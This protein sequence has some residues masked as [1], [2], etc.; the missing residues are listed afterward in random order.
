MDFNSILSSSGLTLFGIFIAGFVSGIF[1]WSLT[2]GVIFKIMF[3][4]IILSV[5]GL[6]V[7]NVQKFL[8]IKGSQTT[9]IIKG[10]LKNMPL[11]K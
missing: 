4:L 2:R 7:S 5:F 3:F 1:F 9:N 6:S 10:Y 8:E 11:G